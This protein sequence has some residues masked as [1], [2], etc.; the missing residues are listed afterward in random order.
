M[1]NWGDGVLGEWVA[2][3]GPVGR[4]LLEQSLIIGH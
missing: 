4:S 2:G 3:S 1:G